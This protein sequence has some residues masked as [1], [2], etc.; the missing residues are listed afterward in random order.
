MIDDIQF[1][2]KKEST[3]VEM[4]HTFN[5]LYQENKQIIFASDRPPKDIP[6]LEER[7][8]TRFEWGLIA[9]VQPPDLET[10]IAILQKKS[11]LEK[12]VVPA[13]ALT[14]M[15]QNCDSNIREME[16]LLNKV[17]LLS[18]LYDRPI[19]EELVTEAFKDYKRTSEETVE[20]DDIIDATL[21]LFPGVTRDDLTGK[22]RDKEIVEPRMICIYL[23]S[24]LLPLPL[25]SIGSIMGGRDHTT[26]MHSKNKVASLIQKDE[27]IRRTV[28]DIRNIIYKK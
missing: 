7:L 12:Y 27:R 28:D 2:S 23:I 19:D 6:D 9:D 11:Q 13:A 8:R 4:F 18:K 16:S 20:V 1:I 21:R 17:I 22:K 5:D 25:T 3:Q 10:R 14:F 24:E 26:I 15:A